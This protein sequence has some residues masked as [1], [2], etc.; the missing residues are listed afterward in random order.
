[1]LQ[2]LINFIQDIQTYFA[3]FEVL[4]WAAVTIVPTS[5]AI[6]LFLVLTRKPKKST[7]DSH[8]YTMY[9]KLAGAAAKPFNEVKHYSVCTAQDGGKVLMDLG[10][11]KKKVIQHL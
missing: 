4:D 3:L 6:I 7:M 11:F 5:L 8:H 2:D 9:R 1:M 10:S